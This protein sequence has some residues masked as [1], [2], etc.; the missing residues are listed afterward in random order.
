[1]TLNI[2]NPKFCLSDHLNGSWSTGVVNSSKDKIPVE[3]A[4]GVPRLKFGLS[5]DSDHDW[6]CGALPFNSSWSPVDL[7]QY[8]FLNFTFYGDDNICCRIGFKDA[9]DNDSLELDLHQ[10]EKCVEAQEC[11]I[12]LPINSF[13]NDGFKPEEGRLLKI[14]GYNDATF[15]ISEIILSSESL[16]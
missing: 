9:D 16:V 4:Q 14:V 5:S 8:K 15:Y 3:V 6:F 13:G 2:F 10:E 7:T 12:S 1:M 11:S